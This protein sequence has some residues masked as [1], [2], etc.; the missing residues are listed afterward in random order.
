MP[1][2]QVRRRRVEAGFDDQRPAERQTLGELRLAQNLLGAALELFEL[3][4]DGFHSSSNRGSSSG[5]LPVDTL[6]VDT[7]LM[8]PLQ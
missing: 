3:L 8:G 2:M 1:E 5:A 4:F 7:L 6:R